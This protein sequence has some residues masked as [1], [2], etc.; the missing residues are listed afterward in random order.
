MYRLKAL[1][2]RT[3]HTESEGKTDIKKHLRHYT[4]GMRGKAC[5]ADKNRESGNRGRKGKTKRGRR[6]RRPQW[7]VRS[8]QREGLFN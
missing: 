6:V 4:R 2:R 5:R 1:I 3:I 8:K 7:L